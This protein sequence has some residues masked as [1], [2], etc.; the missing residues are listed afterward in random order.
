MEDRI[1]LQDFER[2]GIVAVFTRNSGGTSE[3]GYASLNLGLHV[4]DD[5]KRVLQN[6]E[7]LGDMVGL[8]P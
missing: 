1:L 6:R 3:G 8:S 5:P 2:A 7:R 4:G